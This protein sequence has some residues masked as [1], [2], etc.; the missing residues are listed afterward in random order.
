MKYI[1]VD[2]EIEKCVVVFLTDGMDAQ[3]YGTKQV[4]NEWFECLMGGLKNVNTS[5]TIHTVGFSK[6][7]QTKSGY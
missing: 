6:G 1:I 5:F 3:L 7:N 2:K 4:C